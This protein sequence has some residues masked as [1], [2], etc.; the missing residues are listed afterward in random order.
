MFPR[1]EEKPE[2]KWMTYH[3]QIS[4]SYNKKV[5]PQP[6]CV[7]DLIPK[8]TGH[9]GLNIFNFPPKWKGPLCY[10]KSL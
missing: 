6:I 8:A 5:N 7:R 3:M 4:K 10:S 9:K 2:D 1:K